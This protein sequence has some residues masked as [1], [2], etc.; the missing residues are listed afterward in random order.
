M[1]SDALVGKTAS[2]RKENNKPP[3]IRTPA[4]P[5]LSGKHFTAKSL[6]LQNHESTEEGMRSSEIYGRNIYKI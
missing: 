2:E 6:L 5:K 4:M 1:R 3:E